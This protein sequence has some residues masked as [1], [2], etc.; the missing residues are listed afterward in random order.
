MA[1][2]GNAVVLVAGTMFVGYL[3][4][5]GRLQK[6]IQ[7]LA[8]PAPGAALAA[9]TPGAT[10][11][12]AP[13]RGPIQP[14]APWHSLPAGVRVPTGGTAPYQPDPQDWIPRGGFRKWRGDPS[15]YERRQ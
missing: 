13:G 15:G 14:E 3:Y 1:Q 8:E 10:Q 9:S 2:K 5:T 4:L 6:V 12:S 7:V 11:P